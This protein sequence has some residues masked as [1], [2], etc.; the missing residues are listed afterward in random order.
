MKKRKVRITNTGYLPDSPDRNNDMNIIPSNQITMK[1]VPFP[2]LGIDNMGNRQMMM[3]GGEYSFPG[4][5][6]TEIPL[7]KY[8]KGKEV[9]S[10]QLDLALDAASFVP[11][12]I[13]MGASAIGGI[14]NLA[15]GDYTGAALDGLNIIT[16]G[17]SKWFRTA[18]GAA[19]AAGKGRVAKSAADKARFL[20]LASNPLVSKTL[21][22]G[23]DIYNYPFDN[24]NPQYGRGYDNFAVPESTNRNPVIR[25]PLLRNKHQQGGGI[26]MGDY[27]FKDGGLVKYQKTGEVNIAG[28]NEMWIPSES[29]SPEE[30]KQWGSLRGDALPIIGSYASNNAIYKAYDFA[31]SK[32]MDYNQ[33]L[34]W[35]QG[36]TE[37]SEKSFKDKH[38][39]K[40]YNYFLSKT[41]DPSGKVLDEQYGDIPY[42]ELDAKAHIPGFPFVYKPETD[43]YIYLGNTKPI[44]YV[45]AENNLNIYTQSPYLPGAQKVDTDYALTTSQA[46]DMLSQDPATRQ[47]VFDDLRTYQG[48]ENIQDP[49][50]SEND[51]MN[52]Y[53]SLSDKD[54]EPYTYD[55]SIKKGD[56]PE[57]QTLKLLL[58]QNSMGN[59]TNAIDES[60]GYLGSNLQ[61]PV[62]H[63][64]K[65]RAEEEGAEAARKYAYESM[66]TP[67]A[68]FLG[69]EPGKVNPNVA[70]RAAV[71]GS[72]VAAFRALGQI[73]SII[74]E[75]GMDSETVRHMLQNPDAYRKQLEAIINSPF[76]MGTISLDRTGSNKLSNLS[77]T[78]EEA[79]D[80]LD[81]L[82]LVSKSP[83]Y[84]YMSEATPQDKFIQGTG[85]GWFLP[86]SETAKDANILDAVGAPFELAGNVLGNYINNEDGNEFPTAPPRPLAYSVTD[87]AGA[88]LLNGIYK[89]GL[90]AVGTEAALKLFSGL[91]TVG[92]VY[93]NTFKG[94][95]GDNIRGNKSYY[96]DSSV[97]QANDEF[98]QLNN[99]YQ[100][101]PNYTFG[102]GA[103]QNAA[104]NKLFTTAKQLYKNPLNPKKQLVAPAYAGSSDMVIKDAKG[105]R[106]LISHP[107]SGLTSQEI[108]RFNEALDRGVNL[109][110]PS[111]LALYYKAHLNQYGV[112]RID[113]KN[114]SWQQRLMNTVP[115]TKKTDTFYD[116]SKLR[117]GKNQ[118]QRE[119]LD[120]LNFNNDNRAFTK[121]EFDLQKRLFDASSEHLP[122]K[123]T[124]DWYL[125]DHV[126]RIMASERNGSI[127]DGGSKYLQRAGILGVGAFGTL[128]AGLVNRNTNYTGRYVDPY[129]NP[130]LNTCTSNC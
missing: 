77:L 104:F 84:G 30:A 42:S 126:G 27:E 60:Y 103:S 73:G 85:L 59:T 29:M 130:I 41:I 123:L 100:N 69:A 110:K 91:K 76:N 28:T 50:L 54:F 101:D 119:F 1:N 34:D 117:V 53:N 14:K 7:G 80:V 74:G 94:A 102:P 121:D 72:D 92:N 86:T 47:K 49:G 118:N 46:R 19:K 122:T 115:F 39:G 83:R 79:Q 20:E 15:E 113:P 116:G 87:P 44:E 9:T 78:K 112:G 114:L 48:L 32:G 18:Q 25:E 81:N 98:N 2:I 11:G 43:E 26:Y 89:T 82:E 120:N 65:N 61:P 124:A 17:T 108:E 96:M 51:F 52:Y 55:W 106:E 64:Y 105:L 3:P 58:T 90:D 4:Q 8:Q 10:D 88:A 67:L 93:G 36:N 95:F 70:K 97:T 33:Y 31:K 111:E 40:T 63:A 16:G 128:A 37:A 6:V 23:R 24:S 35:L 125:G 75:P 109:L 5:Y 99:L 107:N 13:G 129:L 57:L 22:L 68:K 66:N 62:I 127:L 12:Y 38:A 21:G 71:K 45:D 56:S